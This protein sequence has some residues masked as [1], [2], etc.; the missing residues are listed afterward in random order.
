VGFDDHDMAD[1]LDLTTVRQ[2]VV[3]QGRVVAR[4]LVD[5]LDSGQQPCATVVLPTELVVRGS[6]APVLEVATD[7]RGS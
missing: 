7:H 3:E 2:P 5:W 1:L 4:L 6:T